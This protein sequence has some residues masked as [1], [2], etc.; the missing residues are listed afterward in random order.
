MKK[1]LALSLFAMATF[2][3]QGW[4]TCEK[5]K[6][7]TTGCC[8]WNNDPTNC[9]GIGGEYDDSKTEKDCTDKYGEV[10]SSCDAA[11]KKVIG[12]CNWNTEG[13][14]CWT[15]YEGKDRDGKDGADQAASCG[16]GTN[17]YWAGIA[18]PD[19]DVGG[20]PTSTPTWD[21]KNPANGFC[22]WVGNSYN[23]YK[24]ACEPI[25][26]SGELT[27]AY[28]LEKS[29][30]QVTSCGYCDI[31]GTPVLKLPASQALIVSP[32]GRSLHISS[33]REAMVSLYDMSGARVYNGRVRAGNSVFSLEKVASGSYYAVVQSGSEYKK[34]A[35][36]LK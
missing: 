31:N 17:R 13:E 35:V 8:R 25:V 7:G 29:G 10:V 23:D 6:N 36:V 5:G 16:G 33:A 34:V 9:W 21:G 28:C 19:P 20:C 24:G 22:C 30:E 15:I 26:T 2:V 18:C 27:L 3:S 1:V 12:C 4:A 14:K 11:V 32:Y